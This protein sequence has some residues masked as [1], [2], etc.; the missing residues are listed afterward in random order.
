MNTS[1]KLVNIPIYNNLSIINIPNEKWMSILNYDGFYLISNLGRVKSIKNKKIRI[2]K[3]SI[4][5]NGYLKVVLSKNSKTRNHDVHRLVAETFLINKNECVNH[6]N[7]N[8]IDNR[9]EN[10]E[11]VS[12]RYNT[13][14]WKKHIKKTSKYDGVSF[15]KKQKK[16]KAGIFYNRKN[17]HLG[18]FTKEYDAHLAYQN[19]LKEI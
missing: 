1:T 12:N 8:K 4:N 3:Q 2:L 6:K 16:W 10:L 9:L 18:Y 15:N 14:H 19:A 7:L 17:I 13:N 5:K 11:W